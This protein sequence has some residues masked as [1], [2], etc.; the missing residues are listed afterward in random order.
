VVIDDGN[1]C[2]DAGKNTLSED[3]TVF[4]KVYLLRS[5]GEM[6]EKHCVRSGRKSC[7]Q[8]LDPVLLCHWRTVRS[9]EKSYHHWNAFGSEGESSFHSLDPVTE[10]CCLC[11][12]QRSTCFP[13]LS[14]EDK[15]RSSFRNDM[16]FNMRRWTES[17]NIDVGSAVCG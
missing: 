11:G 14:P 3:N 13:T 10:N 5:S 7:A 2:E 4:Q 8:S 1:E 9:E 12:P 6:V 16:L 15:N 17:E